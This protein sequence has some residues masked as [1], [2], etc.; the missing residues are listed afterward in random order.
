MKKFTEEQL[1]ELRERFGKIERI[2]PCG[3]QWAGLVDI[4]SAGTKEV[5]EQ[6]A[7]ANIRWLSDVAKRELGTLR[8]NGR[9]V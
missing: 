1:A 2:D 5:V 3:A 7:G 4:V 9:W 8:R 6:L